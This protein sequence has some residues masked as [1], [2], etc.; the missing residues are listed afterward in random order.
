MEQ[1][2]RDLEDSIDRGSCRKMAPYRVTPENIMVQFDQL[3]IA[4]VACV[5]A[6]L[7]LGGG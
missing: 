4:A 3:I 5:T 6:V 7:L 1:G 2:E